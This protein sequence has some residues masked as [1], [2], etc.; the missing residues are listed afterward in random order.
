MACKA[1]VKYD[2]RAV[3]PERVAEFVRELGFGAQLLDTSASPDESRCVLQV[4]V[5]C[6]PFASLRYVFV[7]LFV[8]LS[9]LQES[10]AG[11]KKRVF[12]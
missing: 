7:F 8:L 6:C 12:L 9:L 5:S 1:D 2:A 4:F 10:G 3:Q 11:S